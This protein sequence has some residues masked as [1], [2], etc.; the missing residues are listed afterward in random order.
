MNTTVRLEPWNEH[1][2]TVLHASNTPEMT[3]YIGG[4][5]TEEQVAKRHQRYLAAP[6]TGGMFL[7]I[8]Q[9]TEAIA[10][11]IG[12]WHKKWRDEDVFETGWAI[13]PEFQGRGLAAAAA[14]AV[15]DAAATGKFRFMHAFPSV[16]NQASNGIC[17]RVGFTLLGASD[18]EYPPGHILRCN[19]WRFDL[20][21]PSLRGRDTKP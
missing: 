10:G 5:E 4:P 1:G 13:M 2:L 8:E 12:Y 6:D 17:R 3:Q 11:S 14:I 18:F 7:V 16:A 20:R 19:D 15:L 21:T 9:A